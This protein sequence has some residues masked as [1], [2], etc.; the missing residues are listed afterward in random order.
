[1]VM[2]ERTLVRLAWTTWATSIALVAAGVGMRLTMRYGFPDLP[3]GS[4]SGETT[5][6]PSVYATLGLVVATRRPR[7]PVGWLL[8]GCGLAASIQGT[9]TQ[10][11]SLA[12]A[13]DLP[14]RVHGLW[15]FSLAQRAWFGL[16][17]LLFL[18]F[19]TGRLPSPRWRPVAWSL[20]AGLGLVM[21]NQALT[22]GTL[23]DF[24]DEQN[25]FG[26]PALEPILEPLGAV[27]GLLLVGGALGAIAALIVRLRRARGRERQQIKWFVYVALLGIAVIFVLGPLLTGVIGELPHGYGGVV[28]VLL[29]PWLLTPIALAVT[30]A[31]A[32]VRH[33]LYDIDRVINR[34]LVYGLLTLLLATV[35]TGGVFVLGRLLVPGDGQSE[36]AIA[37]STLAVAALFQPARRWVQSL[38]DRRFNRARYD[39]ARTIAAFSTR[40]RDEIDLTTLSTELLRVVDQTVQPTQ[41][42]LWL[43]P[44]DVKPPSHPEPSNEAN[45]A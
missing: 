14:G 45:V 28:G 18:L 1:M 25:P 11:A 23:F 5:I 12:A 6:I 27:G 38:V 22:P 36:L 41:A 7:H 19:P 29:N 33:R 44:G 17:V 16:M 8:M 2:S 35:Y 26:A 20:V 34:T 37:A 4:Y 24:P 10:Y 39:A 15:A 31:A 43:R 13:A 40:L 42:S 3:L 21:L 30:V 9:V 32:I